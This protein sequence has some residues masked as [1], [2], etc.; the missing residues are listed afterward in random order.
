LLQPYVIMLGLKDR[1]ISSVTVERLYGS[2]S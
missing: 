2:P 1:V